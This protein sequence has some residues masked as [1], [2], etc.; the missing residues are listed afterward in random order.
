VLEAQGNKGM[1]DHKTTSKSKASKPDEGHKKQGVLI[2]CS[3][4]EMVEMLGIDGSDDI[5]KYAKVSFWAEVAHYCMRELIVA[6]ER[7]VSNEFVT[8]R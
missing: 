7:R 5:H 4:V 3:I 2:I 6:S 1:L 8:P